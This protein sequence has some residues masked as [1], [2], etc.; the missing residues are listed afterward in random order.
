MAIRLATVRVD[1]V[2]ELTGLSSYPRWSGGVTVDD[3]LIELHLLCEELI[4]PSEDRDPNAPI[5]AEE[6]AGR[7]AWLIRN[8]EPN[9]CTITVKNGCI[10]DGNH[11]FS[12]AVYRGDELVRVCFME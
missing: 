1:H 8:I 2:R 10:Q 4:E 6:H 11:R 9:R 7:V 5:P 3:E 12:A